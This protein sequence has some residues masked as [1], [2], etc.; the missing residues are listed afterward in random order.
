MFLSKDK[1]CDLLPTPS[2]KFFFFLCNNTTQNIMSLH[3]LH[4]AISNS[5]LVDEWHPFK[6]VKSIK[7]LAEYKKQYSLMYDAMTFATSRLQHHKKFTLSPPSHTSLPSHWL[8]GSSDQLFCI[9]IGPKVP[10]S[11]YRINYTAFIISHASQWQNHPVCYLNTAWFL[12]SITCLLH[13]NLYLICQYNFICFSS[14]F[15]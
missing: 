6:I 15:V 14:S 2:H 8:P 4:Y 3:S 5:L 1:T 11:I 7:N 9:L 13:S 10:H 12:L